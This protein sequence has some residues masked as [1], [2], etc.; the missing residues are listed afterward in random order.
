KGRQIFIAFEGVNSAYHVYL[1]GSQVGFSKGAHLPAEFNITDYLKRGENTLVVQIYQW[2][3][4][5]YLEDQDMWRLNGIFRD[6][7]LFSTAGVRLRD[8]RVTPKLDKHYVNATLGVQID[9]RNYTH[10]GVAGLR[11]IAELFDD[12]NKTVVDKVI[13]AKISLPAG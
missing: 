2:S 1:N 13:A 5:A 7:Y 6:G 11:V 3:D 12:Q 4:G 9:L 10:A 8:V